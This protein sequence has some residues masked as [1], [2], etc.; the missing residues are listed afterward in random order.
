MY[1]LVNARSFAKGAAV[2]RGEGKENAQLNAGNALRQID[3][4]GEARTMA[5]FSAS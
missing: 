5:A 1:C 4:A 3:V 2:S